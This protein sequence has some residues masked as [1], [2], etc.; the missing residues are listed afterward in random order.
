MARLLPF[1][2][3]MRVAI[4]TWQGNIS[5]VF[6]VAKNLIMI[7]IDGGRETGRQEER[8]AEIDPSARAKRLAE[9]RVDV[10]ICGAIS[11]PLEMMLISAGVRVIPQVCG[12]SEDVLEAFLSR[13]LS[14]KQ[15]SMPGCCNQRRR[16]RDRSRC[17]RH[18]SR[19]G[20]GYP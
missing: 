12:N 14:D 15:F 7:N 11:R 5:P 1:Q 10:L 9:R 13:Q 3:D 16:M 17:G 6:D 19:K 2:S 8:V 18:S 4:P 20:F